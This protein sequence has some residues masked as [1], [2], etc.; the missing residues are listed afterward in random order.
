MIINKSLV[1]STIVVGLFRR[2]SVLATKEMS[3]ECS[4]VN[5]TSSYT[6]GEHSVAYVTTPNEEVA[7][8]IAKGLVSG[9]LAACIN[10]IPKITSIYEWEGKINEE[11]EVLM[12]IK[13]RTC[14]ID[15]VTKFV[16]AHHP[17]TVCEVISL[18]IQNGND[19]YLKWIKE[20]VPL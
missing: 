20:A 6:S 9:K 19:A 17:Y 7:K 13:T 4:V 10:I 18:P 5:S 16:K 11:S 2:F 8:K 1:F 3:G 14:K 12:M 15:D